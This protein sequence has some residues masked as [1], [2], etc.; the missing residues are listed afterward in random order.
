MKGMKQS[1]KRFT[2]YVLSVL[3]VLTCVVTGQLNYDSKESRAATSL[4]NKDNK[5]YYEVGSFADLETMQQM[6]EG[7]AD[8]NDYSSS[9]F[10]LTA[11]IKPTVGAAAV[12]YPIGDAAG[13]NYFKGIFDGK[14]HSISNITI[15]LDDTNSVEE[16][17]FEVLDHATIKDI[18]FDSMRVEWDTS[19]TS[20][21]IVKNIGLIA[22]R[23]EYAKIENVKITNCECNP[24]LPAG[25]S[26]QNIGYVAGADNGSSFNNVTIS[27]NAAINLPNSVPVNGKVGGVDTT[28]TSGTN[29]GGNDPG[30]ND[31]GATTGSAVSVGDEIVKD[32]IK[33]VVNKDDKLE[34]KGLSDNSVKNLRIP[35]TVTWGDKT[36]RVT[37]IADK[38]FLGNKKLL[39]V[40][41]GKYIEYI[42]ASAFKNCS[43]LKEARIGTSVKEATAIKT[44]GFIRSGKVITIEISA[45]A[46]DNCSK[47]SRVIIN[48]QVRVI[49]NSVF[50]R[51][52]SLRS[53]V[54]YSKKLKTVGKKALKGVHNCKISVPKIKLKP[55]K[56]LFK[57]KG[58]GKKVVVIKL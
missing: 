18:T 31:P 28:A 24:Q 43:K 33:Y 55:Y 38:A 13:G 30:G 4:L 49:G 26:V 37:R 21:A 12:L 58:Q 9:N 35:D 22:G 27:G 34:V 3:L 48:C 50:S 10:R 29:P 57:N 7:T 56:T 14:G 51:C 47:L 20:P 23:L 15:M 6:I 19:S 16:G 17:F 46:F 44:A 25:S 45:S 54:V 11:D 42:G 41:I 39:T 53:I 1:N 8:G 52:V 2:A 36:F 40:W 32:R 5:G